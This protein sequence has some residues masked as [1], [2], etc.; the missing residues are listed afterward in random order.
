MNYVANV[1]TSAVRGGVTMYGRRGHVSD[2]VRVLRKY[3]L[4]AIHRNNVG[5]ERVN[6]ILPDCG[7]VTTSDDHYSQTAMSVITDSYNP[8]QE[9]SPTQ[10]RYWQ[11]TELYGE[12][13]IFR[14]AGNYPYTRGR[15][16]GNDLVARKRFTS[17]TNRKRISRNGCFYTYFYQMAKPSTRF[18]VKFRSRRLKL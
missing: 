12:K 15:I 4:G 10:R 3:W 16:L 6:Y 5:I 11:Q 18:V 7:K 1:P 2:D 8:N 13:R 17:I 14:R 9:P